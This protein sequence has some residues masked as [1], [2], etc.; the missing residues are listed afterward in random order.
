MPNPIA[1]PLYRRLFWVATSGFAI[2]ALVF[3]DSIFSLNT[4]AGFAIGFAALLPSYLWVR[5]LVHGLPIF[6]IV[7]VN[8]LNTYAIP[9][10]SGHPQVLKYSEVDRLIATGTTIG[11]LLLSTLVWYSITSARWPTPTHYK[12]FAEN[13][14]GGIFIVFLAIGCFFVSPLPWEFFPFLSSEVQSALKMGTL[15]LAVLSVAVLGFQWG[16]NKLS[17]VGK[18]LFAAFLGLYIV[19]ETAGLMIHGAYSL[20]LTITAT[21]TL[22]RGRFPVLLLVTTLPVLALLHLG[23]WQMREAYWG[24][25]PKPFPGYVEFYHDWAGYGFS[26]LGFQPDNVVGRRKKPRSSAAE[27]SCVI[28]MLLLVQTKSPDPVPYMAGE[29]YTMIPSLL[30]PRLINSDKPWAHEGTYRLNI[31]YGLQTRAQTRRTTI[32]FGPLAEAYA[33]FSFF[34]VIALAILTGFV[35]GRASVWGTGLPITSFR[36]LFGLITLAAF[37]QTESSMGVIVNSLFQGT[38]AL[39]CVRWLFMRT[40]SDP[41]KETQPKRP[42]VPYLLPRQRT[43]PSSTS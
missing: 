1:T 21:Y 23:K 5:G 6:P 26:E 11:Y 10:V 42:P 30:V 2:T 12:G 15:G 36:G 40:L 35:T 17:S 33:N 38:I 16:G 39:L 22:A 13:R 3:A 9:M 7:A 37:T 20:I 32:G 4:A 34:G 14:T 43:I 18:V 8:Y 25:P 24:E 31:H 29:S 19:I 41:T 28:H 27:R